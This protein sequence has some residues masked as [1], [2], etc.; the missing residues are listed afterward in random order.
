ML[1]ANVNSIQPTFDGQY[2]HASPRWHKNVLAF[3]FMATTITGYGGKE[4][5]PFARAF[6]GGENDVRGFDFFSIT[7]VAYL[8]SSATVNVLNPDG[9][10]R[11]QNQLVNGVLTAVNV[12]QNVP[13]YQIITPGG[14]S[15][16]VFNFEYRIP[17]IGPISLVPFLRRRRKPNPL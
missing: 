5:P 16:A 3:H 11:T 1:G 2:Y 12:I 13:T 4:V 8:P 7:P 6:I 9:S 10:Q 17:I 14:D 15:H